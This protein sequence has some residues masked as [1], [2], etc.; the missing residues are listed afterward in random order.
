MAYS[1]IRLARP[2]SSVVAG[3]LATVLLVNGPLGCSDPSME[4]QAKFDQELSALAAD[5][6]KTLSGRADLLSS[7]PTDE[8]LAAL[9]ALADRAKG[10]SGGSPTQEAAARSLA[11]SIYRT[12]GALAL[13]RAAAIEARHEVDRSLAIAAD[14]LADDLDAIA[15]AASGLDLGDPRSEAQGMKTEASQA[16]RALQAAVASLETP[17]NAAT[18]RMSEAAARLA[19]LDQENAVLLRK[20]RESNPE[21][22]LT[23]VEE[24]AKVQTEARAARTS[25]SNDGIA[26]G[27]LT[28]DKTLAEKSLAAAQNLQS[29]AGEALEL[30]GSFESDVKASAQKSADMAKTLRAQAEA[31]VKAIADERAGLLRA[32][33]DAAATDL[34]NSG[35]SGNL[36]YTI[37]TDEL[38]LKLTELNGLGSHGRALA[39]MM[40]ESAPGYSDAKASAETVIAAVKEKATAA[41]DQLANAGE[42]P[43][44]AP[45]K[46]YFDEVK[47]NA[48][49]MTVEKLMVPPAPVAKP[50]VAAK[51]S[52][53][54]MSGSS[55]ASGESLESIID[56]LNAAAGD[57]AKVMQALTTYIDDSKPLGRSFKSLLSASSSSMQPVID[58]IT[59]KY[60]ADAAA[61]A[62]KSLQSSLGGRGMAGGMASGMGGGLGGFGGALY[63]KLTEKSNDGTTAVYDTGEGGE[64]IFV[65]TSGGWKLDMSASLPPEMS[66]MFERIA[67]MMEA[68]TAPMKAAAEDI[69]AKIRSGEIKPEELATKLREELMKSMGGGFG[70]GRRGGGGGL[71]N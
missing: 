69:A 25:M 9:R 41:A 55:A 63:T 61:E 33:Y 70:G 20:A 21:V 14:T 71:G 60:G 45:I 16:A 10:M 43:T 31:L 5:Y 19:A 24:A 68:M 30:L 54:S 4:R 36:N 42:D 53:R 38:R 65:K 15:N 64:F 27:A 34:G 8:S 50:Q 51:S 58:A 40:G 56:Q 48:D 6:G 62:R 59:E 66:E 67:P 11:S 29:A 17:L 18:S 22:A 12:A 52:G 7:T 26:A 44:L 46:A 28:I 13:S 49:G 1:S 57:E 23:F 3:C 37:M 2:L 32:S 35:A 47:K 39:T